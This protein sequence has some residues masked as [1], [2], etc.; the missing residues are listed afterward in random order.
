MKDCLVR[1]PVCI[2]SDIRR[3]TELILCRFRFEDL[4]P[5]QCSVICGPV[6]S[7]SQWVKREN[8]NSLNLRSTLKSCELWCVQFEAPGFDVRSGLTVIVHDSEYFCVNR[9]ERRKEE[10]VFETFVFTV[11]VDNSVQRDGLYVWNTSASPWCTIQSCQVH[12][13]NLRKQPW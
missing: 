6:P 5:F 12:V 11:S 3:H 4:Y 2:Q 1:S 10:P 7:L 9:N 13:F 8:G